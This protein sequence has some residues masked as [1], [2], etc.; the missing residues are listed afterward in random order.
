MKSFSVIIP[1]LNE[2]ARVRRTIRHV[3]E[4]Y[5][6]V[7][8]I[9]VDGGSGDGTVEQSLREGA[10]V[11]ESCCGR[12]N[13]C[14]AGARQASGEILLFL[15]ADT[16]LPNRAFDLL[17]RCFNNPQTQIGTFRLKF[18]RD[19]W[20]LGVY[21]YFSC[22][23]SIFTRFGDQCIVVRRAFF[24][25][26]GGFPEWP[27]FEDVHFLRRARKHTRIVSFPSAVSTSARRFIKIGII[28][29][30]L[31]NGWLILKYLCG[32]SPEKLAEQYRDRTATSNR[33]PRPGHQTVVKGFK[34]AWFRL[35]EKTGG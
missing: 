15:H 28:R 18:D 5:P 25:E 8:I 35:K 30:Q 33:Q 13:Q 23:D 16:S 11:V 31:I 4:L 19:K 20:I 26:I 14:N 7:E 22:F 27:L 1:T 32:V 6:A 24:E 34:S 17:T 29:T 3:R 12:G 10:K 9:V 2:A 21:A